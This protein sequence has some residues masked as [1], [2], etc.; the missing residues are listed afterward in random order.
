[1]RDYYSG[2]S[3]IDAMQ[4]SGATILL[5]DEALAD[6]ANPLIVMLGGEYVSNVEDMRTAC[7]KHPQGTAM[8]I[9]R[10]FKMMEFAH[11]FGHFGCLVERFNSERLLAVP[12]P[13]ANV[14]RRVSK[15]GIG[16][17]LINKLLPSFR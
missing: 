1:M 4:E 2:V 13:K 15:A 7:A 3:V 17:L 9:S 8:L 11:E 10:N 14:E 16:R 12:E 6:A 5:F